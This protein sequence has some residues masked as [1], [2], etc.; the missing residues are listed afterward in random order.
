MDTQAASKSLIFI[1]IDGLPVL[2]VRMVLSLW[3]ATHANAILLIEAINDP[4]KT[5]SSIGKFV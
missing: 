1:F 5:G 3:N 2:Y 4:N